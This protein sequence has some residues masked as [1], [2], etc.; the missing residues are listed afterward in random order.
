MA[1]CIFSKINKIHKCLIDNNYDCEVGGAKIVAIET[2]ELLV[3]NYCI[4]TSNSSSSLELVVLL[5]I[6]SVIS[7][8][9]S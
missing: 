2:V 9:K 4:Q 8:A 1:T 3:T 7:V 6:L 5:L